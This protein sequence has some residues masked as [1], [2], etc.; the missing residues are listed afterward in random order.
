MDRDDVVAAYWEHWRLAVETARNGLPQSKEPD[1]T[2]EVI[3]EAVEEGD[4]SVVALIVALAE[5]A[6]SDDDVALVGAGPLE[7]L[8]VKHGRSLARPQGA[9][10]LKEIDAAARRSPRFRQALGSVWLDQEVEAAVRRQ[11]FRFF[12][13]P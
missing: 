4:P 6:S 11:L 2:R 7:D 9:A 1:V 5:A 8:L 3:D 12:D 10:L 13:A